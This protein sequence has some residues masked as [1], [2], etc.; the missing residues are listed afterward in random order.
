MLNLERDELRSVWRDCAEHVAQLLADHDVTGVDE[1]VKQGL[2]TI[3]FGATLYL[4]FADEM[5]GE[6][7][8]NTDDVDNAILYVATRSQGGTNRKSHL[9]SFFELVARASHHDYLLEDEH[10]TFVNE[11]GS[12]EELRVNLAMTY[13]KLAKYAREHDAAEDLLNSKDD[14]RERIRDAADSPDSYITT[15]SKPT[16]PIN[17]AVGINFEHA[18]DSLDDFEKGMFTGVDQID[19]DADLATTATPIQRLDGTGN[20]F[21]TITVEIATIEKS[22]AGDNGP[23]YKGTVRDRTGVVE[24]IDWSGCGVCE[25]LEEGG[26]YLLKDVK[27][28]Y[29]KEGAE[30]LE[31]VRNTTKVSEIQEGVGHLALVGAGDGQK[32]LDAAADGGDEITGTHPKILD[33]LRE[34]P[35]EIHSFG[36]VA[37]K[38]NESPDDARDALNLLV[39]KG[40]VVE[41][42]DGYSLSVH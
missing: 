20:P 14:Y 22:P 23:A 37:G 24:L 42:E 5:G 28:S 19:E 10:Y 21:H 32:Q 41:H 8:I 15:Y 16:N 33:V 9:D 17:R 39:K 31:P 36:T 6:P 27:V 26:R 4:Q 35:K 29:D 38:V 2:Q 34:N 13:D 40:R 12:N 7:P 1:L 3:K 11:G 25:T 18:R 30:Q